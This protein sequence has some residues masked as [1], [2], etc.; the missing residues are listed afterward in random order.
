MGAHAS[1]I[2]IPDMLAPPKY[3]IPSC[4]HLDLTMG[5]CSSLV[6]PFL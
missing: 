5:A 3:I 4:S 6:S 2:P 1:L